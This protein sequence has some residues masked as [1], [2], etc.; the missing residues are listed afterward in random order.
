MTSTPVFNTT[1]K[2]PKNQDRNDQKPSLFFL[3]LLNNAKNQYIDHYCATDSESNGRI[4]GQ[5][6]K[7]KLTHVTQHIKDYRQQIVRHEAKEVCHEMMFIFLYLPLISKKS[8][9]KYN[10]RT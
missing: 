5:L 2:L 4:E 9:M 6:H 10:L 3:Q 8:L 1:V 7:T